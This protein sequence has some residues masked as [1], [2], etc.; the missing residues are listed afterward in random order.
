MKK[1]GNGPSTEIVGDP[2]A[3]EHVTDAELLTDEDTAELPVLDPAAFANGEQVPGGSTNDAS[4]RA[5]SWVRD[6][7]GEV[8][9]LQKRW[10]SLDKK[11]AEANHRTASLQ[12]EVEQKDA[13]L[14]NLGAELG[15][16]Q[17]RIEA[18]EATIAERDETIASLEQAST[19]RDEELAA[20]ARS[21]AEAGSR[22]GV[23][24]DRLQAA[25]HEVEGL[26]TSVQVAKSRE[27]EL[28]TE[29]EMISASNVNLR[30]KVHD[31]ESYIDGRR[32]KWIEHQATLKSHESKISSL[33]AEL[34]NSERRIAER[35][36]TIESLEARILELQ[37][38]AGELEGRHKERE[39]AHQET[40]GLLDGRTG[41]IERLRARL[42]QGNVRASKA[43]L[44]A[45]KT[46]LAEKDESIQRLEA[47]FAKVD[48]VRTHIEEQQQAD[49]ETINELQ[50]ALTQL[51]IQRDELTGSLDEARATM[52][53]L[54][55]QLDAGEQA[56]SELRKENEAQKERIS[57]LEAELESRAEIIAG[58]D[59]NAERLNQLSRNL[60]ALD[61]VPLDD[62]RVPTA[63]DE[64]YTQDLLE[65]DAIFFDGDNADEHI[66]TK[67]DFS[68]RDLE[69][70]QRV[71]RADDDS[72][73]AD[74]ALAADAGQERRHVLV[75]FTD[76]NR[77][78]YAISKP[79]TTIGRSV[80]SD[81][82]IRD[83][84]I[85]RV[86]ARLRMDHDGLIVEDA[87]S[88]NG[89]AVNRE[90]VDRAVLRHGDVISLGLHE[91][92]YVDVKQPTRTH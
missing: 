12:A 63:T 83:A 50:Q 80:S 11:L 23:L 42:E 5:A 10:E 52:R 13:E 67:L 40:Q 85:S 84:V 82:R 59:A 81:I 32:E 38:E 65:A 57:A 17:E 33:E 22:A 70:I 72:L 51:Q 54:G 6:V 34:A 71:Q 21:L 58:F 47:D 41:E 27:A 3:G 31:L 69:R 45:L 29:K 62:E 43:D 4:V 89:L 88:K 79:V 30:S 14:A 1:S 24:E 20:A 7:Q 53:S 60:N 90:K 25:K 75:A 36:A 77:P 76:V 66:E 16:M 55:E 56:S 15:T 39:A 35:D 68:D 19:E 78:V 49:R 91:F 8:E 92:R 86:H 46:S 37:R 28:S 74:L 26:R 61:N 64:R 48:A 18:L 9:R 2:K 87:G 44:D 73:L